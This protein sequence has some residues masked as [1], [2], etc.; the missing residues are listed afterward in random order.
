MCQMDLQPSSSLK[1]VYTSQSLN[2][3]YMYPCYGLLRS[4]GSKQLKLSG[5]LFLF[6]HVHLYWYV[7]TQQPYIPLQIESVSVA[8]YAYLAS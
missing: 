4:T 5:G 2:D 8:H 3:E 7:Y 6:S 1:M